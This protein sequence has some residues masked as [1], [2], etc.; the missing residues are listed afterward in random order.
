[1]TLHDRP[2]DFIV[3]FTTPSG[4]PTG[5]GCS[6]RRA[7]PNHEGVALVLTE[8]DQ[9]VKVGERFLDTLGNY[10]RTVGPA[11]RSYGIVNGDPRLRTAEWFDHGELLREVHYDDSGPY[12]E[13]QT[14]RLTETDA[15]VE[16][17]RRILH[18]RWP[19][20]LVEQ[21]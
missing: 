20:E 17:E 19:A 2:D 11:A 13:L 1:M 12:L 3:G 6:I 10:H 9:G 5:R 8:W 7:E 16:T 18:E 14:T 15:E 4:S 21:M